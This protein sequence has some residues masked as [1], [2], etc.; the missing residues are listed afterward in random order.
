MWVTVQALR[1]LGDSGSI[2]E[3]ND[4]A[5]EL[6]GLSD[7]QLQVLHGVGPLPEVNYRLSWARTYLKQA[8]ALDN[9]SR[10]V[11]AITD[12]GQT[13]TQADMASILARVRKKARTSSPRPASSRRDVSELDDANEPDT[14]LGATSA[15]TTMTASMLTSTDPD[16][17]REYLLNALLEMPPDGFER[18]CQR[19]LRAA[20]F[21]KVDVVG[22]SGDGGI[23]GIGVLR[24]S[25]LYV[26]RTKRPERIGSTRI[27]YAQW[28]ILL[29]YRSA[30]NSRCQS[31]YEGRSERG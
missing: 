5:I 1:A 23:D 29:G 14:T 22:K 20:G 10:G 19:V 7:A 18:L 30:R 28:V 11:W 8:G 16:A 4:Q 24:M 12:Y 31:L 15:P 6:A 17:W 9:T 25:L 26:S 2:Q 13:L 21:V 3:I 27:G